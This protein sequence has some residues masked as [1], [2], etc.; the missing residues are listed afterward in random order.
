[1]PDPNYIEAVEEPYI[2]ASIITPPDFVG[3]IMELCQ[4][5]RG[6]HVDMHYLSEQRVQLRYDLPLAEIVLD[7]Y[8]QLKSR[9]RGYASLDYELIGYRES[10]LVKLDILLAGDPVDALSLVVH[11][12][13]AYDSGRALVERLQKKIPRQL[14]EVAIQAAIG[15]RDHRA[16]DR[17]AGAQGRDREVLRRRHHA[18]AQAAREA[19]GGQEAHEAGRAGSRC[20]RTRSWRCWSWGSTK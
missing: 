1:M 16:R 8:D 6:T 7:F 2:R 18:Q 15:S 3:P 12:D 11:K 9:S 10:D 20:P 13:K 17:Q 5:R 4:D 19:E 14:Y